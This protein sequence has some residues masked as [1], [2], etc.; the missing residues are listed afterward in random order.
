[1]VPVPLSPQPPDSPV[2]LSISLTSEVRVDDETFAESGWVTGGAAGS[3]TDD[4]DAKLVDLILALEDPADPLEEADDMLE[5]VDNVDTGDIVFV[6]A[7]PPLKEESPESLLLWAWWF[8]AVEAVA[9]VDICLRSLVLDE[10]PNEDVF[11]EGAEN[12]DDS[13]ASGDFLPGESQSSTGDTISIESDL[14]FHLLA[15]SMSGL[16]DLPVDWQLLAKVLEWQVTGDI[17]WSNNNE[18]VDFA[19]LIGVD[20]LKE[21]AETKSDW[22]PISENDDPEAR[23]GCKALLDC[24]AWNNVFVLLNVLNLEFLVLGAKDGLTM[25]P[26]DKHCSLLSF[27][28]TSDVNISVWEVSDCFRNSEKKRKGNDKHLCGFLVRFFVGFSSHAVLDN[29][30]KL[31]LVDVNH[32]HFINT[33]LGHIYI[34]WKRKKNWFCNLYIDFLISRPECHVGGCTLAHQTHAHIWVAV[35]RFLL[36]VNKQIKLSKSNQNFKLNLMIGNNKNDMY[37][38]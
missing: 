32:L 3:G 20:E 12:G 5:R 34:E 19:G 13:L 8:V 33:F 1:M 38:D 16:G 28:K 14:F 18:G 7:H 6:L 11:E 9:V 31:F 17:W 15:S 22:L 24:S 36:E 37:R 4:D 23:I 25:E 30:R 29:S 35:E 21:V 26:W 2:G 27:F 10:D